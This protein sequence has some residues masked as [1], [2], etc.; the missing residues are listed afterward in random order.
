MKRQDTCSGNADRQGESTI[1]FEVDPNSTADFERASDIFVDILVRIIRDPKTKSDF[2]QAGSN[3]SEDK[4]RG[5]HTLVT[6][7]PIR[8]IIVGWCRTHPPARVVRTAEHPCPTTCAPDWSSRQVL[9]A[10]C[11]PRTRPAIAAQA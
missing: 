3:E 7:W 5:S 11:Y 8:S 9:P 2:F 1:K 6:L 4:V 10:E